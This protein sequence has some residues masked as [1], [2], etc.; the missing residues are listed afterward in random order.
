MKKKELLKNGRRIDGRL[1]EELRPIEMKVGVVSRADGSA[2][3]RFGDTIAIASVYGPR[4]LFPK[5]LQ[6]Q[7]T[8]I[9]RC[10]YNMAPFSVDERKSPGPD[11]RSIE[12]TK[13]IRLALEPVIFLEDFPRATIDVF[14]EIIQADGSTR[15]TAINAASLA[16]ASAGVPMKDLI[17]ACSVGKIDGTLILDLNGEEDKNSEADL[18]FAMM[19]SKNKVTLLQMDGNLTKEEIEKLLELARNACKK[20]YEMQR[21]VL[22]E[23]YRRVE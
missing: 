1:P 18:A 20:I 4:A 15:V 14:V 9:V 12:L 13:V 22:K 6:E 19:P 7:E 17:A 2:M 23:K 21:N 10:R 5:H 16:L 11:R 8:C 3:V